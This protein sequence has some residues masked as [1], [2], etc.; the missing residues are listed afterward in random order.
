METDY[1]EFEVK[2]PGDR[3]FMNVMYGMHTLAPFTFWSLSLI[4]LIMNYVKRSHEHDAIYASHHNYMIG[5]FWWTIMWLLIS[6]PLWF[7]LILPGF[8]AYCIIGLWYIYRCV[9]GW[10]RFSAGEPP[11]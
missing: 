6:A 9:R 5:T 7:L 10:L 3:N 2:G 8:I 1:A 4:A 11:M